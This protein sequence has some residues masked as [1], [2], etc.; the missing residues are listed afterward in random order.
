VGAS[1]LRGFVRFEVNGR[2]FWRYEDAYRE[3]MELCA[4]KLDVYF[5][6]YQI[7]TGWKLIMMK[8]RER[9]DVG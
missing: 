2:R 9:H 6:G 7:G 1:F 5:L 3:A 4:T 8:E